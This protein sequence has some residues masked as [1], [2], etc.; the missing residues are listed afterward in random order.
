MLNSICGSTAPFH[1]LPLACAVWCN[2]LL[3]SAALPALGAAWNPDPSLGNPGPHRRLYE[4]GRRYADSHFDA[5]ANMVEW[6]ELRPP[7]ETGR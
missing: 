1:H 4:I 6:R 7:Y 3:M 5:D 2:C